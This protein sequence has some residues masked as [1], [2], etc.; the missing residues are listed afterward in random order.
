MTHED[1]P[2]PEL[3]DARQAAAR[4]RRRAEDDLAHARERARRARGLAERLRQLREENGFDRMFEEAFG[5]G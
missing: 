4:S 5:S 3:D 1:E 2:M